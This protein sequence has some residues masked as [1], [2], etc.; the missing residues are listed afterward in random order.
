VKERLIAMKRKR[1]FG[2]RIAAGLM[3]VMLA[4]GTTPADLSGILAKSSVLA[5]AEAG[6]AT[7]AD[8]KFADGLKYTNGVMTA[9]WSA[10]NTY[11]SNNSSQDSS[12]K[13]E[14]TSGILT[15]DTGVLYIDASSGKFAKKSDNTAIQVNVG[16]KIYIPNKG[17]ETIMTVVFSASMKNDD[18]T[19]GIDFGG[20]GNYDN[21]NVIWSSDGKSVT[22]INYSNNVAGAFLLTFTKQNNV[23]TITATS[24]EAIKATYGSNSADDNGVVT[25]TWET[26]KSIEIVNGTA[27]G[28]YVS[29]AGDAKIYVDTT[30]SGAKFVEYSGDA[31]WTEVGAGTV[32]FLP[33][34]GYKTVIE[35]EL[36]NTNIYS[37]I[38]ALAQDGRCYALTGVAS[39]IRSGKTSAVIT[40]YGDGKDSELALVAG[41]STYFG[42][43]KC[44]SYNATATI[45]GTVTLDSGELPEDLSVNVSFAADSSGAT[46]KKSGVVSVNADS[47]STGTYSVTVP[48]DA[49]TAYTVALSNEAYSVNSGTTSYA[50]GAL[51]KGTNTNDLKISA[52]EVQK[53]SV[54]VN[55]PDIDSDYLSVL[56][57]SGD[58]LKYVF[59]KDGSEP[60]KVTYSGLTGLTLP[61]GTY[62]LSLEGA[63]LD[64][65]DA[66]KGDTLDKIPYVVA[67]EGNTVTVDADEATFNLKL[68]RVTEWYFGTDTDV[69]RCKSQ[70]Q[71]ATG[72]YKGLTLDASSGKIWAGNSNNDQFNVNSKITVPVNGASKITVKVQTAEKLTINGE[73]D[74]AI[75]G[76]KEYTYTYKGSEKS[77]DIVAT[78]NDYIYYIK[79]ADYEVPNTVAV[80]FTDG[81]NYQLKDAQDSE[82]TYVFTNGSGEKSEIKPS[83]IKD[84]S[85][86]LPVGEYTLTLSGTAIDKIPYQLTEKSKTV[87]VTGTNDAITIQL[88]KIT[89]WIFGSDTD[90]ETTIQGTEKYYKGLY[91]VATA[92]GA[93]LDVKAKPDRA[94]F[95]KDTIIRVPV[96]EPCKITVVSYSGYIS[97]GGVAATSTTYSYTYTGDG[98][99]M[100][101]IKSTATD[102]DYISSIAVEPLETAKVSGTVT[103][104]GG[105]ISEGLKVVFTNNADETEKYE[106]AVDQSNGTYSLNLPS[107]SSGIVYTMS[108]S[109][110]AY[111]ITNTTK[112]VTAKT[113]N[114][115]SNNISCSY[116]V[117][118]DV[119][120][121]V[122]AAGDFLTDDEKNGLSFTFSNGVNSYTYEYGKDI[123]L[124]NGE[125]T[126]TVNGLADTAYQDVSDVTLKVEN[127]SANKDITL[128]LKTE[129][130]F[131]SNVGFDKQIQG[132]TGTYQGLQI[133]ATDRND[134]IGKGKVDGANNTERAQFR[135]GATIS[136]PVEGPCTVT[137]YSQNSTY[138]INGVSAGGATLSYV[139]AGDAGYVVVKA[140]TSGDDYLTEIKVEKG[141]YSATVSGTVT[142]SET[143]P[144][145]LQLI[146]TNT[147]KSEQTYYATVEDGKYSLKLPATDS[148]VDF[149]ITMD[150]SSE[151]D[152]QGGTVT[153]GVS[154]DASL[155]ENITLYKKVKRSVNLKL[156]SGPDLSGVTFRFTRTD[157]TSVYY[158]FDY[159]TVKAG[160]VKL[161]D[162]TYRLS[163]IGDAYHKDQAYNVAGD[164]VFTVGSGENTFIVTFDDATS[165]KFNGA[166][167]DTDDYY[168]YTGTS[169]NTVYY[170]GLWI[171][172]TKGKLDA[173]L[174][175]GD[176]QDSIGTIIYVP[177]T[178]A[179]TVTVAAKSTVY[180]QM[181]VVGTTTDNGA[182]V[183]GTKGSESS[184]SVSYKYTG[185]AGYVAVKVNAHPTDTTQNSAYLNSISVVYAGNDTAATVQTYTP[186][187]PATNTLRGNVQD[188]ISV[189]AVGQK[190]KLTQ[191]GGDYGDAKGI[192]YYVFPVTGEKNVLEYDVV[193]NESAGTSSDTGFFGGLFTKNCQYTIAMRKASTNVKGLYSKDTTSFSSASGTE[194]TITLGTKVHYTV[195]VEDGKAVITAE[196]TDA[197]GK[198]STATLSKDI[199]SD[200]NYYYGMA[201]ASVSAVVTNMKYYHENSDGTVT[202]YYYQ[203][204][205]YAPAGNVPVPKSVT[206]KTT[207]GTAISEYIRVSW[208]G[209]LAEKDGYYEVWVKTD[210][211]TEWKMVADDIT[212]LYY[213]YKLEPSSVLSYTFQVVGVLGKESLGG[214]RSAAVN[215][216]TTQ[217][218]TGSLAAPVVTAKGSTNSITLSWAAD[219]N[220]SQYEVY[221]YSYDEGAG[222]AKLLT[223]LNGYSN[224]TYTDSAVTQEMPYYYYVI[225]KKGSNVSSPS[226]TVWAVATSGHSGTYVYEN[227]ATEIF[228]TNRSYD[229]VFSGTA[230]L[231]GNVY[232]VGTLKVMK[233]SSEVASTQITSSGGSFS[234]SIP[235]DE[236]RNDVNLLFTDKN[237]KVTRET[238]NFVYLTNYDILVDS[239]F[240]GTNGTKNGDGIPQYKTIQA[241]VDS[242]SANNSER[243]VILVAAGD[244][245]ERLTVNKPNVSII[246][247]DREE[248]L[249]HCYPADIYKGD[250]DYEAG[251]DMTK[252]CATYITSAATNFSA[253]NISFK[254][255]YDYEQADGK[256]N[257]SADALRSD[258]DG[259]AFANVKL[260]SYQDTLYMNSGKQYFYKCRIEGLVDY[261]YTGDNAQAFFE[262]CELVFLHTSTKLGGYVCAPKTASSSAYGLTFYNCVVTGEEGCSGDGYLLARPWGSDAY[263]TW[264][265]C[266][267]GKSV[268]KTLPYADMNGTY[269]AARF[270]EYGTYG[271]GFEINSDR[272]QISKT[273]ADAMV[274][275]GYLGWS[276]DSAITERAKSYVGSIKSGTIAD[277]TVTETRV[278]YK[279]EQS[280]GDDTTVT[281]IAK[282]N[283]E[284]YASV[285]GVTGGGLQKEVAENEN[286]YKV[287][288]AEEFLK[289]LMSVKASGKA[290][291]IEL[292]ADI[293]LG[294]NEVSNFSSYSSVIKAY[295]YQALLHPTLIKSGTSV[296]TITNMYNLTI[297]SQNGSSIKHAN[298]TFKNSGNIIIRNIKFDELWEW[299]E[300]T[301]G[302]YD[303]NDW[304]YMTIDTGSDGI[305]VDHCTFYKAYD[306]VIDVKNPV[307]LE[308]VTISWCEFLPGSENDTFFDE[309]MNLLK[310]NPTKYKYY[311][312]LLES[313]MTDEEIRLYAY[314][315]KK[316]HLFGQSAEA[317]NA[318]GIRVTLANN[319]YTNS[320]DRMPRLRYG[321]AH[322]Y[323]CIMDASTLFTAKRAIAEKNATAAKHIVSNGVSSTC[324]GQILVEN[325]YLNNIINALN[326]GNGSDD[327]GYINAINSLYYIQNVRYALEP[328]V[329]S[330]LSTAQLKVLTDTGS[331]KSSLGYSYIL[332][333][334]GNLSSTVSPYAGAGKLT[335]TPLQ[336][337]K[338]TYNA[339]YQSEGEVKS[340]DNTGLAKSPYSS[341]VGDD[342]SDEGYDPD[343]D[344]DDYAGGGSGNGGNNNN[345]GSVD[346]VGSD[347]AGSGNNNGSGS[348]DNAG[349][350]GNVDDADTGSDDDNS[351]DDD[352][353]STDDS[354]TSGG[355]ANVGSS[356]G[357]TG[358]DSTVSEGTT[359]TG[360][361]NAD[362]TP[363][364]EVLTPEDVPDA[365]VTT[366]DGTE[367]TEMG[368]VGASTGSVIEALDANGNITTNEPVIQTTEDL[369]QTIAEQI[370]AGADEFYVFA[371]EN[372]EVA[373]EVIDTLVDT[374]T[375]MSIGIVGNNGKCSAILTLD[376]NVLEKSGTNFNLKITV[377]AESQSV[378][379]MASNYGITQNRYTV[380][381]FEYSGELPGVFKVAVDVSAKYADGT[382]LALYY[383]NTAAGRLEN[384]Y[385]VTNV[386][387]G[388]AEFAISH[389]SEYVLVDVS[390]AQSVITT[391]TLSSP[392]TGD[393]NHL[394]VWVTMMGI[395]AAA[396][397]GYGAYESDKKRVR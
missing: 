369:V 59:T 267:M 31:S 191:T 114:D 74:S 364:G 270:Y 157:K 55:L 359:E 107:S 131:G 180:S 252:R 284:G 62:T 380:V 393:G 204:D 395:V 246:G 118:Y 18:G 135:S 368:T 126:V 358:T 315:Q 48:Y 153:F 195:T 77:V 61:K 318:V 136:V 174:T 344:D 9:T 218:I 45:S 185:N 196:F 29:A 154:R 87:S 324:N 269:S 23:K 19:Y 343:D 97:I 183:T 205:A 210:R 390:A 373:A 232:G 306:G 53:Y 327:S 169:G 207:S 25:A 155:T 332:R 348:V 134:G 264:I 212:E 261:I 141:G 93:K 397:F 370:A 146:F 229:T 75:D 103:V 385:Q 188:N 52:G 33:V 71:G 179:C 32:F 63:A 123:K 382:R 198:S 221:R 108:M 203:N 91:V 387:G 361:D 303:R 258:A 257:K 156:G 187:V 150:I 124:K 152:I 121:N 57:G 336:W 164:M 265:N 285:Y 151:Y 281:N 276:P 317:T 383:N 214:T 24:Y 209:D 117:T 350:G 148:S 386:R 111:E 215:S 102:K 21:F 273:Q 86:E 76:N 83:D 254:N 367:F 244:Y 280:D 72:Y 120:L 381:D 96:S 149:A 349:N 190:L 248:T 299:D 43:I 184:T 60:V 312:E 224:A 109:E 172:A 27:N 82:L 106:A 137:V 339:E 66:N 147:S 47:K 84:G 233:G 320:M 396:Y 378:A 376:G 79:V 88:E 122:A 130:K 140:P 4:V 226:E 249:V 177:V 138:S 326:S 35:I 357:A 335:M 113:N 69:E 216:T 95:N 275:S 342:D 208:D 365:T 128:S 110:A 38:T 10:G 163:L 182:T 331:F 37:N 144:D 158:E 160:N 200:G 287:G 241:A 290:S 321:V 337:E 352:N 379:N 225:A 282:Y 175:S 219:S 304:D 389:C 206:A 328:H 46:I 228:I 371:S 181:L 22:I 78:D 100:I 260:T 384:Q 44:T 5:L 119:S 51:S 302:G 294:C 311:N 319:T 42:S 334:A 251:G 243:V 355:A 256:S 92:S 222:A 286:Y 49:T 292:T 377:D 323:N 54:K 268:N 363:V 271:P 65:G 142:C 139:Y 192:S 360:T 340:Y 194:Y 314:G 345:G 73:T 2:K 255:D 240:S 161:Y 133:D 189:N 68:S 197:Q 341:D 307:N 166:S 58:N 101:E 16:T 238:Y 366:I 346:N 274:S 291:T 7:V 394:L 36:Q 297:F 236:G 145:G 167:G 171:D 211:D 178:G 313:G 15:S 3:A 250:K 81:V 116:G 278:S 362:T 50:A 170:N 8:A 309:M 202:T 99:E 235:L 67:G 301:E 11:N 70:L 20:Y 351:Y 112:T 279:Y 165:W 89:K 30:A 372:A 289:A 310:A 392:K 201:L 298:I 104:D 300:F 388:F 391:N 374:K 132:A 34:S 245:N 322:V 98:S 143:L 253:E 288:T 295:Q 6:N 262:D 230:T 56:T 64:D 39:T 353:S 277:G 272:R 356:S 308:R 220:A 193:I 217:S 283:M 239:S 173:R 90:K 105:S 237:N 296:V 305:W 375:T 234:F 354:I 227:E 115:I 199:V 242:V 347:N 1:G 186:T 127:G 17:V 28:E 329:N 94:Q 263:V 231:E 13:I 176:T 40:V 26:G 41:S 12:N 125:Y 338:T 159:D 129:W 330:T 14:S 247:Q 162:G 85:I 316:T 213:D 325:S 80:T 266:Y 293:N 223:T 168:S 333:D 259:A